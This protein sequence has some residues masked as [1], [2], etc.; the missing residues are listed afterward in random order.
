MDITLTLNG[1]DF[2]ARVSTYKVTKETI[3]GP[4]VVTLDD[5]EHAPKAKNRDVITFKLFPMTGAVALLDYTA[6]SEGQFSATY[7][8]PNTNVNKTK[9][10]RVTSNLEAAFGIKGPDS[11]I[12]YKGGN[13][14][15]RAVSP[16]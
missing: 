11:N 1:R 5:V 4:V 15:L 6:L 12:Y 14:V 16:N 9:T 8:D 13:I 2:H 3:N 10:V 7:T